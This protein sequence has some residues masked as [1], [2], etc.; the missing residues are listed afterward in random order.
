LLPATLAVGSLLIG[1]VF[2][3]TALANSAREPAAAASSSA[4]PSGSAQVSAAGEP[5]AA[6]DAAAQASAR[7]PSS[8]TRPIAFPSIGPGTFAYAAGQGKVLGSAGMLRRF[9]VAVENGMDQDVA[10]FAATVDQV[11]GDPR[12]WI[13][14][15]ALRLQR[16]PAQASAEFTILLATPGTSERMCRRAGLHTGGYTSCRLS[17]KVIIN[18]ARWLRSVPGYGAPLAA[19]QAYAINHEVG[20]ELGH[21]HEA[22]PGRGRPAPVMQQQTFGLDGCLAYAWPYL[23]GR[24]YQGPPA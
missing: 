14:M 15:G 17:G 1:G 23:D 2:V 5:S 8:A 11:L 24:R 9:R 13:A 22:C 4:S 6:A 12:S 18:V 21:R 19:Y 3:H 10:R 7:A 20:H 16:V